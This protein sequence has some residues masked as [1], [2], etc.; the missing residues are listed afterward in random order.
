MK[1]EDI[2]I[3]TIVFKHCF[4]KGKKQVDILR[5]V[6]ELGLKK[7]EIR[8]ELLTDIRTEL[9]DI[10][11]QAD[12]LHLELF[13]S[14]N[15]D[16]F[17]D[18]L[19]N[20]QLNV[21]YE[22]SNILKAPFIKMNTGSA[23][24]ISAT[25]WNTLKET[26]KEFKPIKV[27]NNQDTQNARILNCLEIMKECK[28]RAIPIDFVFD[29]ANWSFVDEETEK[30]ITSLETYTDYLHCKN[31]KKME[32]E[33]FLTTLFEGEIDIISLIR[34]FS[35]VRY[36]ALE[37]PCTEKELIKDIDSLLQQMN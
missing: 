17:V 28:D 10:R 25:T 18:G 37:Y 23:K 19:I 14:I 1:K 29:T 8:R 20:S 11:H 2:I 27:E 7:I 15:E 13:Y 6:S 22:E 26:I 9:Q 32:K 24:N 16:L 34:R 35:K 3:N 31:Y 21:F 4:D 5:T 12:K 30:A 36:L 33:L